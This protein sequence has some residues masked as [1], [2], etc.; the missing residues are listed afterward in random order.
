MILSGE[1]VEARRA[2]IMLATIIAAAG[3]SGAINHTRGGGEAM[4]AMS[5]ISNRKSTKDRDIP[6]AVPTTASPPALLTIRKT[7]R[8]R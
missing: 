3:K 6:I 4:M 1:M 5:T 2:G 8:Q 7:M